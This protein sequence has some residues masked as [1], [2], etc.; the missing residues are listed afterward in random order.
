MS[1]KTTSETS[2]RLIR[3]F[4][5][6]RERVYNA[7]L[8]PDAY[9]KWLPPAGFTGKVYKMEARVGGKYR[10]SFTTLDK[11]ESH[12]FGGTYLELKPNEKI[13]HT[14]L[15]ETEAPEMKG[16][17]RVT[18]TFKDVPGG[19]EVTIVH[20]GIPKVIGAKNAKLGWNSSLH[21]LAALVEI[22]T[23]GG[24]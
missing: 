7:F 1:G 6:P 22:E 5:A 16:E 17:M 2:L 18:I 10:M 23:W 24:A 13:V 20:D 11:K 9:A 15:F 4:K 19:T 8:D 14:D 12:A 21:N 3:V